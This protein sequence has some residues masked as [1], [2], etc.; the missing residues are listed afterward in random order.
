MKSYDFRE[1]TGVSGVAICTRYKDISA[2]SY[3]AFA[4]MLAVCSGAPHKRTYDDAMTVKDTYD[5]GQDVGDSHLSV[6]LS[7]SDDGTLVLV[8]GRD[9]VGDLFDGLTDMIERHF[10]GK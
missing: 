9:G 3:D 7:H 2:D 8:A 6:E 5:F 1:E 4:D 10:V